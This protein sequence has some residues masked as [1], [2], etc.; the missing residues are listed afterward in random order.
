MADK[1]KDSPGSIGYVEYQ[2]AV[3]GNIPQAAVLNAAG[4]YVKA[5]TDRIAAACEAME[6]PKWNNFSASLANAPGADS[7]P[8]TSFTWIYLRT[9]SSDST[10]A[11]A[12]GNLLDW[13]YTDGQQ[14]AVQEG[15]TALPP[16]PLAAKRTKAK[17]VQ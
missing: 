5:S 9:T 14:S 11:A 15:Y 17:A 12:L 3:K 8:I 16:Q 2:Y 10:R 1:V 13:I 6:A 4:K 7:Y